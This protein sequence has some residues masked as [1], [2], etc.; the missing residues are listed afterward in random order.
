[1]F[2]GCQLNQSLAD[3]EV[4]SRKR[5]PALRQLPEVV[6]RL[7]LPHPLIESLI[8]HR[9]EIDKRE[10]PYGDLGESER[11][12]GECKFPLVFREDRYFTPVT[13]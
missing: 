8:H 11:L 3:L 6:V 12:P 5:L 4:H 13:G 2:R 7:P 9:I 1:M 10:L